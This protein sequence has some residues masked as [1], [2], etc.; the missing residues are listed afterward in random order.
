M[1]YSNRSQ[2]WSQRQQH[3]LISGELVRNGCA[4]PCRL[5]SGEGAA[6]L[7]AEDIVR[8]SEPAQVYSNT[9]SLEFCCARDL[10]QPASGVAS[11]KVR[12]PFLTFFCKTAHCGYRGWSPL[13]EATCSEIK[14]VPG[15]WI[16]CGNICKPGTDMIFRKDVLNTY[17]HPQRTQDPVKGLSSSILCG[18]LPRWLRL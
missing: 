15:P 10:R 2:G 14:G 17:Q 11:G 3:P 4:P 18:G 12:R 8:T 9:Q 7:R 1:P 13:T 5:D 6:V 16:F